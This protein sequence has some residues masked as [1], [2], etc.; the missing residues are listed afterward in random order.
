[1]HTETTCHHLRDDLRR[2][3]DRMMINGERILITRH[4]KPVAALV[5]PHDLRA[6]ETVENNRETLLRARQD[7]QLSEFQEMKSALEGRG[8]PR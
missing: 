2:H 4:G 8:E 6:L 1:M 5:S 3:L 7:A